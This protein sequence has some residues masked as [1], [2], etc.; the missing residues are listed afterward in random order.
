MGWEKH[1]VIKVQLK[2]MVTGNTDILYC[3]VQK[4]AKLY[5]T[6]WIVRIAA[7]II[8]AGYKNVMVV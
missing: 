3:T 1:Q 2:V 7:L 4:A 8:I 5:Y 6:V